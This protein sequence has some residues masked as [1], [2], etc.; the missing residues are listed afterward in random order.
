MRAAIW[1]AVVFAWFANFL[2]LSDLV[3]AEPPIEQKNEDKTVTQPPTFPPKDHREPPI[4]APWGNDDKIIVRPGAR[5]GPPEEEGLDRLKK[6]APAEG[7]ACLWIPS[8]QRW[9]RESRP[10]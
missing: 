4:G 10:P 2:A 6:L 8:I 1:I 3:R 5:R 7:E 9:A